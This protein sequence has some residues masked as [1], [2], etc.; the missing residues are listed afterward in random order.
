MRKKTRPEIMLLIAGIPIIVIGLLFIICQSLPFS[1]LPR[2]VMGAT[3]L[4]AGMALLYAYF[5]CC[6]FI[7]EDILV[8]RVGLRTYRFRQREITNVVRKHWYSYDMHPMWNLC[9]RDESKE[10]LVK[11]ALIEITGIVAFIN[12][13]GAEVEEIYPQIICGEKC[14][15]PYQEKVALSYILTVFRKIMPALSIVCITI[16]IVC[17][18]IDA[19]VSNWILVYIVPLWGLVLFYFHDV[20]VT[21][22]TSMDYKEYYSDRYINK[23]IWFTLDVPYDTKIIIGVISATVVLAYELIW[24]STIAYVIEDKESVSDAMCM[25]LFVIVFV[26]VRLCYIEPFWKKAMTMI[27]AVVLMFFYFYSFTWC[28][29]E[30]HDAIGKVTN[31]D[32]KEF[33]QV[34]V[35]YED[36]NYTVDCYWKK[37]RNPFVDMPVD[38]VIHDSIFGYTQLYVKRNW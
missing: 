15:I 26:L 9:I 2:I 24:D 16:A 1:K 6:Y 17:H 31:V 37:L 12:N 21:Q 32:N 23:N 27:L 25:A 18:F 29:A 33:T 30:Y 20:F 8:L 28:F 11:S 38:C 14:K 36:N 7:E 13:A 5:Y 22:G 10:V 35:E 3:F 19:F 4:I 34:T